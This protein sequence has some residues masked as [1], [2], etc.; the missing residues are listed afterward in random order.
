MGL[1]NK[2]KSAAAA[3]QQE[4]ERLEQRLAA[5]EQAKAELEARLRDL[6]GVNTAM[7]DRITTLDEANAQLD[8]RLGS[9]DH[10]FTL[11][12]DQLSSLTAT[13][14]RLSQR[15]GAVDDLDVR[16]RELT[17]RLDT[18]VST[19]PPAP[20]APIAST[21]APP[22]PVT[23]STPPPSGSTP[24]PPPP[25]VDDERVDEM[26]T[27]LDALSAAV[28]AHTERLAAT[29]ARLSEV[30][31]LGELLDTVQRDEAPDSEIAVLRQQLADVTERVNDMDTRVTNVSVELANQ[32]TELS[33]DIDELNRRSQDDA[34]MA[35][36]GDGTDRSGTGE[37]TDTAEIEA[38]LAERLDAAIDDVLGTTERLAAEQARYEIQFRADLAELAE[39]L[40]R[41]NVQ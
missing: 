33:R 40:R 18:P 25:M 5:T 41:P 27:Q 28:A 3:V 29:Q 17:D 24:P 30:E 9:L 21:P 11:L 32:L 22:P 13:N 37:E 10:G 1:F 14:E 19:P 16:L 36:P 26:A 8:T 6:D 31:E 4:L 39:R 35:S 20:P 34:D 38:R 15:F 2:K 7:A 12:G 23:P